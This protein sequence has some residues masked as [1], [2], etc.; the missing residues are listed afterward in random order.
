MNNYDWSKNWNPLNLMYNLNFNSGSQPKVVGVT[1]G[2]RT[3]CGDGSSSSN[4]DT[5]NNGGSNNNDDSNNNNNNNDNNNDNGGDDQ[6][7]V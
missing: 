2:S 7:V 5:S 6:D 3:I 1:Q 4:D